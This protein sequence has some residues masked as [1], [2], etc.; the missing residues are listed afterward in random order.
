MT[1]GFNFENSQAFAIR[2]PRWAVCGEIPSD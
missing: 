1:F 2:Q